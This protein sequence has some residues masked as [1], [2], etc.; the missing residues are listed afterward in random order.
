MKNSTLISLIASQLSC[1]P[2][3]VNDFVEILADIMSDYDLEKLADKL[4]DYRENKE[5]KQNG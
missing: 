3:A 1:H 2:I 5:K 4:V